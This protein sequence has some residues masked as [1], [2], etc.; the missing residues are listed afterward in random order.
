MPIQIVQK[1]NDANAAA[2]IDP[3]QNNINKSI[4]D[5]QS[6]IYQMNPTDIQ[7]HHNSGMDG[8]IGLVV[9]MKQGHNI[10]TQD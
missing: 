10:I 6:E 4:H 3:N 9:D 2:A 7:A 1:V 5:S 8:S